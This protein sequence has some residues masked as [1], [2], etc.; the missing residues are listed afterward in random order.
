MVPDQR[1]LVSSLSGHFLTA[2]WISLKPKRSPTLLTARP[3]L[4]RG[5]LCGL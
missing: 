5:Q 4:L 1:G 3:R 2:N